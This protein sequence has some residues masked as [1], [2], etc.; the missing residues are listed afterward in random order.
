MEFPNLKEIEQRPKRYWT[1]D[2]LQEILMGAV[3]ILWGTALLLPQVLQP[4]KWL[5][6]YWWSVLPLLVAS[7]YA[8]NWGIKKLKQRMTFPRTGY[9]RMRKPGILAMAATMIMAAGVA[10]GMALLIRSSHTRESIH[11]VSIAL[12]LLFAAGFLFAAIWHKLPHLLF[13][14][15][16]CLALAGIAAKASM[17]VQQAMIL[18][19]LSLGVLFCIMGYVRLRI[20]L[21]LNPMQQ[22]GEV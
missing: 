17:D 10:A 8:G 5:S 14:S 9:V 7:G 12:M 2:G 6:Y 18:L 3:W 11:V 13:A 15:A 22:D 1:S 16:L 20:Y 21:K 19:F 4:G